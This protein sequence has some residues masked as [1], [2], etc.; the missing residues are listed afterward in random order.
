M[1]KTITRLLAISILLW[2]GNSF[3]ED[4]DA[5][6]FA[7]LHR[8]TMV[9]PCMQVELPD[10]ETI[11]INLRMN[12]RGSALLWEVVAYDPTKSCGELAEPVFIDEQLNG[13]PEDDAVCLAKNPHANNCGTKDEEE[14][15]EPEDDSEEEPE[16]EPEPEPEP[17]PEE[18][19]E[20]EPEE[21]PEE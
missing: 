1:Y 8:G 14:E 4:S 3:A 2:I 17:E 10:G 20:P 19:P 5:A 9:I 6:A 12:Q 16:E 7:D 13:K 21:E 15:S 11:T 18:E